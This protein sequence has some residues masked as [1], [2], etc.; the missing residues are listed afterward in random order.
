LLAEALRSQIYN[1]DSSLKAKISLVSLIYTIT[2]AVSEKEKLK[3]VDLKLL[4]EIKKDISTVR[5]IYE[6]ILDDPSSVEIADDRRR[7]IE[8]SLDI[9]RLQLMTLIHTQELITESM[10]KEV[11]GSRWQ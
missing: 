3:D 8:E 5:G 1:I 9:T 7:S 4:D 10:I 6:P 11:Q 2:A